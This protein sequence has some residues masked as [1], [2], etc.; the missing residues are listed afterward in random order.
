MTALR[1]SLETFRK[2]NQAMKIVREINICN[3]V[4]RL[5]LNVRVT[6]IIAIK[7]CYFFF[8]LGYIKWPLDGLGR[9]RSSS[10]FL[11]IS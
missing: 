4:S 10:R 9:R 5:E 2:V 3:Q 11:K 8:L 1:N 7:L 6:V